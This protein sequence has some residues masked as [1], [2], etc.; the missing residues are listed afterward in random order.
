VN[1]I[2]Q[3]ALNA[4]TVAHIDQ[5]EQRL[6]AGGARRIRFL[7][8]RELNWSTL[9]NA[10][11]P[12]AL[13][14]ERGT[15]MWDSLIELEV[16]RQHPS[17]AALV[18]PAAAVRTLFNVPKV[19]LSEMSGADRQ[20]LGQL[21]RVI[22]LDSDDSRRRPTVA[23][24]DL[25]IGVT[26]KEAP[27]TIL[28]LE[29]SNKLSKAYQ[30]GVFGK[31]GSLACMFSDAT[32]FVMRKQ[33]EMLAA[34]EKD[35]ITVA[36]VRRD[37]RDDYRLPFFRYLVLDTADDPKGLP[38]ACPASEA[39]EF[40]PGVYVAHI[41]YQADRMGQ[42]TWQQD[43]SIY[44]YAET[45]LLRPTLP[46]GL[47]DE[48]T[49]P[50]NQRPE[51]RGLSILS[52]LGLRLDQLNAAADLNGDDAEK[53]PLLRR[54]SFSSVPVHGV[55][56]VRVRWWL[57]RDLN[58][59]RSYLARGYVTVMTHDGQVH[60]AWDQQRFQTLVPSR[61]RVAERIFVEVD[62]EEV[63][64]KHRIQ[65]LSSMREALRKTPEA[66]KLE[67]AIA[68]WLENDPDLEEA[69][70]KLTREALQQTAQ[71]ITKN[72]LEKLNRAIAAKVPTFE[73]LVDRKG[74]GP[75]PRPPKPQ[76]ELYPEPT[77]FT[78]P[79]GI[80]VVPGENHVFYMQI[81]A[82]DG[83]VPTRGRIEF[84]DAPAD[85][86]LALS[87]GDLRRGRLQLALTAGD[88]AALGTHQGVLALSWLRSTGGVGELKWPLNV[89]ILAERA[90]PTPRPPKKKD[91]SG[92][93]QTG[94]KKRSV[95]ALVWNRVDTNRASGWTEDTAGDLQRLQGKVLAEMN[96]ELYG[97]LKDV[98]AEV[99][100]IVLNEDFIPWAAYERGS[101]S[102]GDQA[103][104]NRRDRYGIA[105]G[106]AIA[107][108]W[109]R[110]DALAKKYAA[111]QAKGNGAEDPPKPMDEVQRRRAVSEAARGILA[112]LP[113]FDRLATDALEETV[114]A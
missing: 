88:E 18:S 29:A 83:F 78:G 98:D 23:F 91:D 90:E 33:P 66:R 34:G 27:Y 5:L 89:T 72:F 58:R 69:E 16:Q 46:F 63:P 81:N 84:R 7:G 67:E 106:V 87:V 42:S 75:K 49:P 30:H 101:A 4:R 105:L 35:E 26:R 3:M 53:A 77:A 108:L 76:E 102:R 112:L 28:S 110:E 96:P 36:V 10:A 52:G 70:S 65:I 25:G 8:D 48:R 85:A 61:R 14:F 111:W 44:A 22:L 39:P 62:L 93:A 12:K 68:Q 94:G 45:V 1:E 17:V 113:D 15:N 24:R 74:R 71:R 11:D 57:F 80:T 64:R 54:S 37:D 109:V 51:G 73:L 86:D 92:S 31:G 19:G 55:G 79:V 99:A 107:N 50:A 43:D 2:V 32:V 103:M 41:G 104:Q 97:E 40:E 59:R 38:W 56:T 95:I 47:A 21:A 100:T 13:I 6:R 114:T 20:R 82:I 9:S 60:H